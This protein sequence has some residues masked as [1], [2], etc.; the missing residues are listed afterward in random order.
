[1]S[2]LARKNQKLMGELRN[3][4]DQKAVNVALVESRITQG[5]A[6]N[7]MRWFAAVKEIR[8]NP[9]TRRLEPLEQSEA[10]SLLAEIENLTTMVDGSVSRRI[11]LNSIS[12][13]KNE[14]DNIDNGY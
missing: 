14:V 9:I 1:M 8:E 4:L 3:S 11:L 13:L 7:L 10:R 6:R 12:E 2:N 5:Q